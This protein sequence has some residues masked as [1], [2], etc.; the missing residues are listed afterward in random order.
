MKVV[1]TLCL[2]LI[3]PGCTVLQ[4]W[5]AKEWDASIRRKGWNHHPSQIIYS[6]HFSNQFAYLLYIHSYLQVV[7]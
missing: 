1:F 4:G 5:I 2:D 6:L 7:E 3:T